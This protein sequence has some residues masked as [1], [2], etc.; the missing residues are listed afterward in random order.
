MLAAASHVP[1]TLA[2]D[3]PVGPECAVSLST[4]VTSNA[5]FAFVK[6]MS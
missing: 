4:L 3:A 1:T 2:T 6:K 5:L